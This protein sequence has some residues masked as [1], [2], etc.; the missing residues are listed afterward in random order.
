MTSSSVCLLV[1]LSFFAIISCAGYGA[2][3]MGRRKTIRWLRGLLC[4]NIASA[5]EGVQIAIV[6]RL[7]CVGEP[8]VAPLTGHPCAAYDAHKWEVEYGFNGDIIGS[9]DVFMARRAVASFVVRDGTGT[10]LVR[11]DDIRPDDMEMTSVRFVPGAE[12]EDVLAEGAEVVVTGVGFWEADPS[13]A[14]GSTAT[15]RE[16]ARRMRLS[17]L[18]DSRLAVF[19]RPDVVRGVRAR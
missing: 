5:P 19:S 14:P 18:P 15:Y 6:G 13:P 11:T 10:V 17:S 4:R 1:V 16:P 12:R 2:H 8:L 9:N 3:V 7:C